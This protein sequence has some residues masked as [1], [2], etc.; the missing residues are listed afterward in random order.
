MLLDY[1]PPVVKKI[2][3]IQK[4]CKTE[5][6]YFDAAYL[7]IENILNR[8]FVIAAD[9]KGIERF[10]KMY[11]I[12]S[13]AKEKL[14]QR[15]INIIVKNTKKN[16]NISEVLTTLQGY[17][18]KTTLKCDYD[19]NEV[20]IELRDETIDIAIIYKA[21]DDIAPLNIYIREKLL[22][23][24]QINIAKKS[25]YAK[26]FSN[27]ILGKWK[28]GTMKFGG[29]GTSSKLGGDKV[30]L[31]PKIFTDIKDTI[32]N[33][34]KNIVVNDVLNITDFKINATDNSVIV[35]FCIRKADIN[36]VKKISFNTSGNKEIATL[37]TDLKIDVDIEIVQEF[38]VKEAE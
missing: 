5:Q 2:K 3:T 25:L 14:E 33:D 18:V 12:T 26:I 13:N 28:I 27:Y 23:E 20:T 7:E 16:L 17:S 21:L 10:E 24:S 37:N 4:I 9:E 29:K 34:I 36:N 1:L 22:T 38:I 32:K 6:P 19:K 31:K 8:A 35:K 15:R 30:Q 11:G